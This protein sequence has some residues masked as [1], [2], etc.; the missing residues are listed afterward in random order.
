MGIHFLKYL[1]QILQLF[2]II[3][4]AGS[5][6]MIVILLAPKSAEN[7]EVKNVMNEFFIETIHKLEYVFIFAM[8]FLWGGILIH[9]IIASA[10]PFKSKLYILYILLS[11]LMSI[12][13]MIK[14]FFI[15]HTIIKSEKSLKLFPQ[16]EFQSLAVSKIENY[17]RSYYFLSIVNLLIISVIILLN[18]YRG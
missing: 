7:N 4:W 9:I 1:S 10:N 18:Q 15:Q 17:K 12:I 2:A 8:I 5:L 13:T 3:F 11:G 14:I 16:N 6:V